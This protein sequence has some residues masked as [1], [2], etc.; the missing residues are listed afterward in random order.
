MH[1]CCL[2]ER[3]VVVNRYGRPLLRACLIVY[4]RQIFTAREAIRLDRPQ[5]ARNVNR[6]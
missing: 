3:V 2:K 1:L 4:V 5:S 6:P